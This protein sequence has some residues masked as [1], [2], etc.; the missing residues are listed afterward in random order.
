MAVTAIADV[1]NPEV[2]ADQISAKFPDHLVFGRTNL[3]EVDTTFPL[4]TPGTA[5]KMP[6]WK[7]IGAFGSLTEG[8]AM[9]PGKITASAEFAIVERA[10]AAW[11]VYD[12]AQ[13]V[14]KA[15][16]VSEIADQIARR[17][18]EYIDSSIVAKA[19]KTPNSYDGSAAVIDQNVLITAMTNTLGDNYASLI[20]SGAI[21]MHSKPFGDLLKTAAIQNQYVSGMDVIRTGLIP[22]LLGLPVMVSDRVTTATVSGN[23]VYNTYVVGPGALALFYQR[24]VQVEFDRDVLLLADVISSN[25]HFSTHLYGWDDQGNALAWEQPKSIH[26]VKL[27]TR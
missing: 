21:I 9:T 8:V 1:I 19:D 11:E 5:F 10:G 12:T 14:T 4:G 25:V 2:L 13:L 20:G 18:A 26:C 23:T 15:D 7:R 16:P 17:A 6:F 22:T 3:V 27:Q 24:Q